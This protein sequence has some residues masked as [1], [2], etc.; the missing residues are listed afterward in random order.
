MKKKKSDPKFVQKQLNPKL[1]ELQSLL[2]Y[3][4]MSLDF[5]ISLKTS[6]QIQK[7]MVFGDLKMRLALVD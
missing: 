6:K 4:L 1:R 2:P 7:L 3:Y 5:D